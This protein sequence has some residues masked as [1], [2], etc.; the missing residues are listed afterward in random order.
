MHS[1]VCLAMCTPPCQNGGRCVD[2]NKCSCTGGWQGPRCQIGTNSL[3]TWT[4]AHIYH[5]NTT[6]ISLT[7]TTFHYCT[8]HTCT[9]SEDNKYIQYNAWFAFVS[10]ALHSCSLRTEPLLQ[11][12]YDVSVVV[13]EC[14]PLHVLIFCAFFPEPVQCLKACQNGGVCVGVNRCRCPAGFIG[15]FCENGMCECVCSSIWV[16][17]TCMALS[18]QQGAV[19][20]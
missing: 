5:H 19:L 7:D 11:M 8:R 13:F 12:V 6:R 9:W 15:T 18:I 2:I 20:D 4:C 10:I 17:L 16:S 1:C 3:I 14:V